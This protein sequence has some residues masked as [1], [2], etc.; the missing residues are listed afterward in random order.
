MR[1]F[2]LVR[3][4]VLTNKELAAKLAKLEGN[5]NK[6]F[7]D[8]YE[9]LNYLMNEKQEET[10]FDEARNHTFG[11]VIWKGKNNPGWD[12]SGQEILAHNKKPRQDWRG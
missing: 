10:D 1:D 7:K 3:Q 6:Q 11:K 4:F 9:V 12:Q 5:Y 2:V 8:V